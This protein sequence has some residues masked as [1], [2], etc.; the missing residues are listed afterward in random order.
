MIV[1]LRVLLALVGLVGS[2]TATVDAVP[3]TYDVPTY[4]RVDAYSFDVVETSPPPIKSSRKGSASPLPEVRGSSTTPH[5]RSVATNTARLNLP[6]RDAGLRSQVDDVVRHFDEFGTPPTGVAQGGLK[7]HPTGT[8]GGQGLPQ[9][10]LG[11]YT[12]SDVWV[13]G[14]GV[15]RGAER[16]VFGQGGEVYYTPTHYD[17]FVRIR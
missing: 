9:K 15:K 4:A 5:A 2:P 6:F 12:E 7:G 13:S 8:Y 1:L 3:F 16:L 17:D 14:G 10:P 11:Y